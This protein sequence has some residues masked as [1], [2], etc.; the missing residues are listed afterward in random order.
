MLL[1]LLVN[2]LEIKTRN[3]K[4]P[5]FCLELQL[6]LASTGIPYHLDRGPTFFRENMVLTYMDFEYY[7][8]PAVM[9]IGV[10]IPVKTSNFSCQAHINL[11]QVYLEH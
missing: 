8:R 1:L 5:H 4:S 3:E 7:G 10:N 9:D 2:P 6:C 11:V